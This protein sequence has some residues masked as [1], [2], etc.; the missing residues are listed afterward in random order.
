[1]SRLSNFW[2]GVHSSP[3]SHQA[4]APS[5]SYPC[6]FSV[7]SIREIAGLSFGPTY[8][9]APFSTLFDH[10]KDDAFHLYRT[11]CL[12]QTVTCRAHDDVTRIKKGKPRLAPS[13]RPSGTPF[14][15]K[16]FIDRDS[17]EHSYLIAPDVFKKMT[18]EEHKTELNYLKAAQGCNVH[19]HSVNTVVSG[20]SSPSSTLPSSASGTPGSMC[21]MLQSR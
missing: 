15:S 4:P 12:L 16:V 7:R 10:V 11:K 6:P 3:K 9:K 5:L 20:N 13:A 21:T 19:V 14:D 2:I 18:Q 1:M 17:K 8:Q